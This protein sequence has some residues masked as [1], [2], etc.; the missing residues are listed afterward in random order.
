MLAMGEKKKQPDRH[1]KPRKSLQL[2]AD[3]YA[4]AEGLAEDQKQPL[5]WFLIDL[6][7]R[8]GEAAGKKGM[9]PLPWKAK[10]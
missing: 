10:P 3:W 1:K 5:T 6:L 8:A 2:P 9:P 7:Q 4:F